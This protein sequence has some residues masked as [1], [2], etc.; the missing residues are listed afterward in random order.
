MPSY[1]GQNFQNDWVY[2]IE[3]DFQSR[4]GAPATYAA[5]QPAYYGDEVAKIQLASAPSASSLNADGTLLAVEQEH[6]I[7][8]YSIE[9]RSL[10]HVL[11]GHVSRV[12][13][14]EFHPTEPKKL[15]SCAMCYYGGSVK[16]E[17]TIL[18][19]DLNENVMEGL[20]NETTLEHIGQRA[21]DG[22]VGE[23]EISGSSWRLN[24]DEKASLT[25]DFAKSIETLNIKSRI[26]DN[27][28]LCGR[29]VTS[30]G[31]RSFNRDGSSMI[32]L[33]GERPRSNGIDDGWVICIWDTLRK[34]TK[35]TL[36]GHTDALMWVG[37]SFDDNLIASVSWDK[38]FRIWS[39]ADGSLLH[40]FHSNGQNWTGG[41]SPDS[42]FFAGTAVGQLWVW[43]VVHGVEVATHTW[44]GGWCR[45]LDW[46]PGGKQLVVGGRDTGSIFVFNVKTQR[47]VQERQLSLEKCP[48]D[49]RRMLRSFLEVISV[50]YMDEGRKIVYRTSGDCGV[51]VYDFEMNKKWRFAPGKGEGGYTEGVFPLKKEMMIAS[52]DADAVRFWR[53]DAGE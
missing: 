44:S 20:L 23:L 7:H 14:V 18:F 9:D 39:H 34:E 15:I 25:K 52:V 30:F 37:F 42:R 16:A 43:D 33:P 51:E 4:D 19:W 13:V 27:K 47:V 48:E 38:T 50:Q 46:S 53:L 10:L 5:G 21:V 26:Q 12:D 35:L 31:G 40:T 8:I 32:F 24:E 29:L 36:S 1:S 6:D 41:F 28:K 22:T 2:A 3:K 49:V 45:H 11:K 17:P